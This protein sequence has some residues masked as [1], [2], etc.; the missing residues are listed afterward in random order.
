[1]SVQYGS[2]VWS[3]LHTT[4]V[5]GEPQVESEMLMLPTRIDD[6]LLKS[7]QPRYDCIYQR[8]MPGH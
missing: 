3:E 1:M 8:V 4:V 2:H 6:G 7:R 5:E